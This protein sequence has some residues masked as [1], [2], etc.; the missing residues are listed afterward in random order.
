M[1]KALRERCDVMKAASYDARTAAAFSFADETAALFLSDLRL[2]GAVGRKGGL[3]AGALDAYE[4]YVASRYAPEGP[5]FQ[6]K[7]MRFAFAADPRGPEVFAASARFAAGL[8][9][10]RGLEALVSWAGT[11]LRGEYEDLDGLFA[12]LS[13]SP[14]GGLSRLLASYLGS[15]ENIYGFYK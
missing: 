1:P 14:K 10:D 12:P 9:R 6:D 13:G 3:G 15:G 4:K 11:F 5:L 8:A 7:E 2:S